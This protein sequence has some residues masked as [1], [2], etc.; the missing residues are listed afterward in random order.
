MIVSRVGA[1][2]LRIAVGLYLVVHYCVVGWLTLDLVTRQLGFFSARLLTIGGV[3]VRL[4]WLIAGLAFLFA[5]G[6]HLACV[7]VQ[8]SP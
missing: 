6:C 8:G 1:A 7:C 2:L 5:V 4:S 3:E